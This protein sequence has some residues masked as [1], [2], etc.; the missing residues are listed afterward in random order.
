MNVSSLLD[1]LS[2]FDSAVAAA[3]GRETTTSF[4]AFRQLFFGY[5]DDSVTSFVNKLT[6]Q[7][8]IHGR[9]MNTPPVRN[10]REALTKLEAC[11]R[12][13]EAKKAAD[14]VAKL[15]ELVAGCGQASVGALVSDARGWL[16]QSSQPKSKTA[17]TS[18]P[19]KKPSVSMETLPPTDYAAL[20]KRTVKDNTQF[21]QVIERLRADREIK[22]PDMLEVARLFLGY[23]LPKKKGRAGAL[24]EIIERQAVEA[25]QEAKGSL[26]DRL[27]PW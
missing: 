16:V 26:L 12:S 19:R 7:R 6:K 13:A 24:Q 27:K 4:S 2:N 18:R 8:D 22:I 1:V 14:D 9:G 21:D 3:S 25:R 23:E 15:V 20:L 17:P 10:L 5:E 11:L